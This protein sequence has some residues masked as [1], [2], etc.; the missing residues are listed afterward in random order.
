MV[1]KYFHS[2][3]LVNGRHFDF[4]DSYVA[5]ADGVEALKWRLYLNGL[6]FVK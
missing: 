5:G 4:G 2:G 6:N 1:T 3:W